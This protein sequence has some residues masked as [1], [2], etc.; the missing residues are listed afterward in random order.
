LAN[1]FLD[2]NPRVDF[3]LKPVMIKE[4]FETQTV[5][6]KI[7]NKSHRELK[8]N[9]STLW[10]QRRRLERTGSVKLY[11]KTRVHFT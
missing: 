2:G 9:K 6:E 7:L 1:L 11:N 8:M 4:I 10:Y 5:K 3:A